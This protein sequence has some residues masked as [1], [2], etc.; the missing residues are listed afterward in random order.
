MQVTVMVV[1]PS[2]HRNLER[3][4]DYAIGTRSARYV[5]EYLQERPVVKD[6]L[7]QSVM[8]DGCVHGYFG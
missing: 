7:R 2:P 5:G 8:M 4:N 6:V 1:M 3:G